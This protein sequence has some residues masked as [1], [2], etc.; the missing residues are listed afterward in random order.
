MRRIRSV[1]GTDFALSVQQSRAIE[2]LR[3][4]RHR[5]RFPLGSRNHAPYLNGG[6][7]L[8][9]RDRKQ[10]LAWLLRCQCQSTCDHAYPIHCL[11]C[12]SRSRYQAKAYVCCEGWRGFL[13]LAKSA[14]SEYWSFECWRC[15]FLPPS[16]CKTRQQELPVR[17]CDS[18]LITT[19]N[20]LFDYKQMDKVWRYFI[21][22]T[23]IYYIITFN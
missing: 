23:I 7:H 22:N 17:A 15:I 18:L 10:L 9:L 19:L 13:K 12:L 2:E 14:K 8:R 20:S 1:C 5:R 11:I 4:K 16:H 21:P 6:H 3:W